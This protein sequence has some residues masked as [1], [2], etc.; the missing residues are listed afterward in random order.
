MDAHRNPILPHQGNDIRIEISGGMGMGQDTL[1]LLI[2]HCL[3]QAGFDTHCVDN[4]EPM[5]LPR[6]FVARWGKDLLMRNP[7]RER[8]TLA[9]RSDTLAS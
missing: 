5:D 1:L 6:E 7:L 4:G 9:I 2:A 8:V 3:N